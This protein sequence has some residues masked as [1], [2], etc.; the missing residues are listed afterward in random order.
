MKKSTKKLVSLLI[1]I[2]VVLGVLSGNAY[3]NSVEKYKGGNVADSINS[4]IPEEVKEENTP[5]LELMYIIYIQNQ[6]GG[7]IYQEFPDGSKREMGNVIRA[8][9]Y[10]TT[11]SAGFWASHYDAANDG[12]HSGI[13]ATASNNVHVRVG[14][15]ESYDPIKAS[16]ITKESV[17]SI[18]PADIEAAGVWMPKQFTI[19]TEDDYVYSEIN[20]PAKFTDSIIYTDILGG[21]EIFGGDSGA[22]VGNPVQFLDNDQEWKSLDYYYN[23]SFDKPIPEDLRIIVSKPSIDIGSPVSIEIENWSAGDTVNGEYK[24]SNGRVLLNYEDGTSKHIADII[25][26]VR[27]TGRFGGSEYSHV[28]TFRASHPG[29]ICLSTSPKVGKSGWGKYIDYSGGIQLVPA[30]HAKFLAYNLDQKAFIDGAFSQQPHYG[31]IAS[32][33]SSKEDL[34]N[35]EYAPNGEVTFDPILEAVAPL[36]SQYLKPK[37]IEDDIENS[38]RFIISEDFGANWQD[39]PTIMGL[40]GFNEHSSSFEESPVA[41]WTNIKILLEY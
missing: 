13:T 27:G 41:N 7:S 5:N 11:S 34:Y 37:Y 31:I 22:F 4:R 36:Y 17:P 24:E 35:P 10:P 18:S 2:L 20:N 40:T 19:G 3:A 15:S 23:G 9:K 28:G 1:G 29:V 21:S 26:R 16:E 8:G 14:P 12:S 32:I 39:V 30:N 38:T 25:Q 33:G 6:D